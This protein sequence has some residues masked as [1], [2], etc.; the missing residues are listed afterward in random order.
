MTF[1]RP[2]SDAET[3]FMPELHPATVP[4]P[5]V[6]DRCGWCSMR[7]GALQYKEGD[8][9]RPYIRPGQTKIE[10]FHPGCISAQRN[11]DAGITAAVESFAAGT[12]DPR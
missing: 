7:L 8:G 3:M 5:R 2:L 12:S 9:P 4:I 10:H 6:D 1:R 11:Q